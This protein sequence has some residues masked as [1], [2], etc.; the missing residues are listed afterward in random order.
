MKRRHWGMIEYEVSIDETILHAERWD[1]L[2]RSLINTLT[3]LPNDAYDF[4]VKN[5]SFHAGKSQAIFVGELKKPYMIILKRTDSQSQ[6]A[7]E[8]AHAFLGHNRENSIKQDV[9]GEADSLRRKWGFKAK[10]LCPSFPSGCQDC[11]NYHC[12]ESSSFL[13]SK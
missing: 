9:D 11:K 13:F 7:H 1:K 10:H 4:V 3:R 2:R 8:I 5:V 12:S 6:V